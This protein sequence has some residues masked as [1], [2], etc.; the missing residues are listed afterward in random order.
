MLHC[1]QCAAY[2]NVRERTQQALCVLRR[3]SDGGFMCL[4]RSRGKKPTAYAA[5]L[6]VH[7]LE[8]QTSGAPDLM[9][10]QFASLADL[11]EQYYHPR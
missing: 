2:D 1:A 8:R 6:V 3:L 7:L 4:S 5:K 9:L 10:T 11:L